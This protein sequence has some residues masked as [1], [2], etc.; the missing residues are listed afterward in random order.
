MLDAI[1]KVQHNL[2]NLVCTCL[3]RTRNLSRKHQELG[4]EDLTAVATQSLG[5][6]SEH[7]KG[8]STILLHI[9]ATRFKWLESFQVHNVQDLIWAIMQRSS[10]LILRLWMQCK[11]RKE[12]EFKNTIILIYG[13][14]KIA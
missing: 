11:G 12:E 5:V 13:W 1:C 7:W 8:L 9:L 3:G 6:W 2:V 14:P 4:G 10:F